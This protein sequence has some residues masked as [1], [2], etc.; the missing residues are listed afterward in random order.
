MKKILSLFLVLEKW[1][2]TK[3]AL[4]IVLVFISF[5]NISLYTFSNKIKFSKEQVRRDASGFTYSLAKK[6]TYFNYYTDYFPLATTTAKLKYSKQDALSEIN[7]NGK[8]LIMEYYHWSRLGEH[9]RI[10]AFLPDAWLKNSPKSPSIHLF[11]VLVFLISLLILYSGFWFVRKPSCGLFIVVLINLTPFYLFEVFVNQNIFGLLGSTFFMVMGI[12]M[13]LFFSE[14]KDLFKVFFLSILTGAIIGF[15]SEFRNEISI[16]LLT[17]IFIYL[18]LNNFRFYVRIIL[19]FIAFISFSSTKKVMRSHFDTKFQKTIEL[20]GEHGGHVYNGAKINGHNFWHPLFCGLGDFDTKYGY[21]WNDLIAYKYAIP[22]LNEK[23]N[24]NLKYRPGQYHLD[25][26]YDDARKYY[27]KPEELNHYETVMKD[28]VLS[29]IKN[30]PL[31]YLEIIWK[32]IIRVL[33]KTLP[34][35]YLGFV[36][37]PL[38]YY[39][40]EQKK[41]HWIKLIIVSLPLSATSI[42]IYSG[43]GTTYNSVFGYFVLLIIVYEVFQ[44]FRKRTV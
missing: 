5:T 26:Y 41:W 38:L 7:E 21:E 19:S 44:F 22:E 13:F 4:L 28:K 11:N 6:F 1:L 43:R 33:T 3:R 2:R 24:M 25:Q 12:N 37:I 30:D 16:V 36:A 42:I 8:N 39:L 32:R 23:Y 20:V 17:L 35:S 14:K 27:I 18:L 34:Y 10:W 9:A 15:F 40:F 31:W 29:D